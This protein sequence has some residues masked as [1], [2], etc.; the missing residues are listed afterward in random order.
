MDCNPSG[1]SV[2]GISQARILERVAAE[3]LREA[4]I[5]KGPGLIPDQRGKIPLASVS[6]SKKKKKSCY[7]DLP[8]PLHAVSCTPLCD[9]ALSEIYYWLILSRLPGTRHSLLLLLRAPGSQS[10]GKL[11][12][13]ADA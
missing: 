8:P 7:S 11:D 12:K 2:H 5:A 3:S 4:L 1:S 13:N 10:P 6:W 9:L